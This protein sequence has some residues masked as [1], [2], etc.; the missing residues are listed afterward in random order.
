MK[1]FIID[2]WGINGLEEYVGELFKELKDVNSDTYLITNHY[3]QSNVKNVFY[4]FFKFSEKL[5]SFFRKPLRLFEYFFNY[6]KVF[7]ILSK[8][9]PNVV[10]I[11]WGL[12]FV[13]DIFF[14]TILK[15]KLRKTRF[16]LTAHNIKN[17]NFNDT[18][19]RFLYFSLFDRIIIHGYSL[20]KKMNILRPNIKT[21]V[22]HHGTKK[23]MIKKFVD[24]ENINLKSDKFNFLFFGHLKDNKGILDLINIW[25]EKFINNEKVSLTIA[26]RPDDSVKKY[27]N[28]L[29]SKK[30]IRFIKKFISNEEKI[31]LFSNCDCVLLPY[32]S[33]SVSGVLFTS[34]S[35]S[36]VV[37]T[38]N[39][40]SI[41]DY[42]I[43][44]QTSFIARDIY[45]FS[46]I[47]DQVIN[48]QGKFGCAA[49][50]INNNKHINN[51][52]CWNSIAQKHL[53]IYQ[54][55]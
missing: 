10:H 40:G 3:Y 55:E 45:H 51:N 9:K 29:N 14:I 1:I 26:G 25:N 48:I 19:I 16:I 38:T 12:F 36:K 8:H 42:I 53:K 11:Q 2:P 28:S 30:N 21:S 6:I 34:A 20:E 47:M 49:L 32:K 31:D 24:S 35:Y 4:V 23:P 46:S 7:L 13:L 33:G 15:I 18:W 22:I 41:Q 27:I 52:F 44:G 43:D 54:F 5:T 17:H 50:G 39:F 37:I